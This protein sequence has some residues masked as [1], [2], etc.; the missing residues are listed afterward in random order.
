M[1]TN[2]S[3]RIVLIKLP[4]IFYHVHLWLVGIDP[5][6]SS[7]RTLLRVLSATMMS[8]VTFTV[9]AKLL[10]MPMSMMMWIFIGVLNNTLALASAP[11][12]KLL[13]YYFISIFS[14]GT[15]TLIGLPIT[16]NF[17]YFLPLVAIVAFVCGLYGVFGL[18]G[19]MIGTL[20][21]VSF[22]IGF[23]FD[24]DGK[25]MWEFLITYAIAAFFVYTVFFLMIPIPREKII[26]GAKVSFYGFMHDLL[27]G[28]LKM[29]AFKSREILMG[30]KERLCN[31]LPLECEIHMQKMIRLKGAIT[32]LND[33]TK[34]DLGELDKEVR[35]II[36]TL[37][38]IF[39]LKSIEKPSLAAYNEF[40]EKKERLF[41]N[42]SLIEE[43][44]EI[45]SNKKVLNSAV[46]FYCIEEIT[47]IM[48]S[49]CK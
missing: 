28:E 5:D 26:N 25:Y 48:D 30:I 2:G 23:A 12:E 6:G 43:S 46:V 41:R 49:E 18:S 9:V 21:F 40:L 20:S 14:I 19:K 45:L 4:D 27:E 35:E 24:A 13:R 34:E 3:K 42:I 39:Y 7:R 15:M 10:S 17:A 33:H 29:D 32:S 37:S 11:K 22:S 8:V 36:A 44:Q 16:V 38:N 1:S 31:K 47:N